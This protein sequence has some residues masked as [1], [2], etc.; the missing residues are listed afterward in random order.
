MDS[1]SQTGS[2][3]SHTLIS[4]FPSAL[5]KEPDQAI[6]LEQFLAGVKDGKWRKKIADLRALVAAGERAKYDQKKRELPAVTISCHCLSREVDL[7]P[8]AK[9]ITHSGWLQ[10][11]FDLK[12]NPL[13]ADA[14]AVK[15]KR[16]A[17]LADPYVGAVFVGPSGE[18]LK[19]VVSIDPERHKDSWFA[20]EAH[21]KD[22]HGLKLDKATKDPMRLCFVSHDPDLATSEDASPLPL[23][24]TA[25]AQLPPVRTRDDSDVSAD[26]I[27]EALAFIPPHPEYEQWLRISSAVW[28]ALPFEEGSRILNQWSPEEK[29]GEYALK[30]KARLK[31]I[32]VG[33][34]FHIAETFGYDTKAHWRK[35][36]PRGLV[37]VSAGK[38]DSVDS[39]PDPYFGN[40]TG[41]SDAFAE[42]I[43][44][45]ARFIVEEGTWI[46]FDEATGWHRDSSGEIR[47]LI[48]DYARDLFNKACEEAKSITDPQAAAKRIATMARLGDKS[49]IEPALAFAAVNRQLVVSV[50]DLDSDPLLLGVRNG[51]VDFRS[52]EFRPHD[53]TVMVT[54]QCACDFDPD[55]ECPTF[56][57]FL[58][59]VQPDPEMR[60]FLQRLVGYTLTGEIG[61]HILPFHFGCGANGKGTFL[62]QALFKLLGSYSAKLTDGLIYMNTKG[63]TPDLEIAGLC[64]IRFALGEEN[65]EGGGLNEALLK[66]MTGG[67]RQK[68]RF[69]YENFVEYDPTAKIHLVGNHKPRITGRDDGIWRRFRLVNW[70][71]SIPDDRKDLHLWGKLAAEF[72]GI[73]NWAIRGKLELGE[74]GTQ[75]PACVIAATNQFKADCDSFGDFLREK[76]EDDQTS[77]VT[78][79]DLFKAYRDYCED[80]AMPAK[81]RQTK[82]KVGFLMIE[83]GYDEGSRHGGIKTWRG[84]RLKEDNGDA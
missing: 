75:P 14:G 50:T 34:L 62:E 45:R 64:G 44:G 65:S 78:K 30:W 11:D 39:E 1:L 21:F 18:G 41:F 81:W 40:D 68:G 29:E 33:T 9:A 77:T 8:E 23:P 31:Q 72:P 5:A 27:A 70:P 59:D 47:S 4:L 17:L 55:A 7:S 54:R 24:A 38:S 67:D 15:A 58:E 10:A 16:E 48:I 71:V 80:Q 84:I 60:N 76:T 22:A 3:S 28:D 49:R 20:A 12:D 83:R 43:K 2:E 19:A 32:R 25:P 57:A 35:N 73:L 51:V 63:K 56:E 6:T 53:P 79:A 82:R 36:H 26:E 46:I 37:K 52:G 61:E 69:H 74:L 66:K 13:L 42:Q